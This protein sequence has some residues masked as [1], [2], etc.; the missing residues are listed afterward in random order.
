MC[1]NQK[2]IETY[3]PFLN[4][5]IHLKRH[6]FTSFHYNPFIGERAAL[7]RSS[8]AIYN[9]TTLVIKGQSWKP[10]KMYVVIL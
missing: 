4:E 2:T 10:T 6:V 5:H 7:S 1:Q 8:L 3:K 9:I